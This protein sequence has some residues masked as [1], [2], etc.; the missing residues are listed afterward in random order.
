MTAQQ[1]NGL[2]MQLAETIAQAQEAFAALLTKHIGPKGPSRAQYVRYL[3]MQ[4]HLTKG[5][6]R[7][8]MTAAAHPS[9]ARRKRLRE[10]LFHFGNEEELHYLVA[11]KDLQALG[12]AIG[13]C[14]I[15]VILWHCYFKPVTETSPFVRLGAAAVLENISGGAASVAVGQSLHAS[16][17][18]ASNTK[19]LVLHRHEIVPHG[20]QILDALAEARPDA[21]MLLELE[22]GACVATVLYLRMAEWALDPANHSAMA[23]HVVEM[24]DAERL[25]IEAFRERDLQTPEMPAE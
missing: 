21:A 15:D 4:Y 13:P 5:V 20:R 19:F 17:L 11:F 10:F 18:N 3:N 22:S 24:S 12:E 14:P 1:C 2:S 7:Y 25:R 9:L 8:F 23:D 16:F 6:Q